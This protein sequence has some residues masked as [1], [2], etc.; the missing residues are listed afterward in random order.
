MFLQLCVFLF[1]RQQKVM[2][3]Y[4]FYQRKISKTLQ[5]NGTTV[6]VVRTCMVDHCRIGSECL[7]AKSLT[8][9]K[10]QPVVC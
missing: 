8:Q 6:L 4:F 1:K 10:A 7:P 9:E 5:Q 2:H 3:G